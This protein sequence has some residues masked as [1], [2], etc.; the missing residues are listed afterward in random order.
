MSLR[1]TKIIIGLWTLIIALMLL[2]PPWKE[3][4]KTKELEVTRAIGCSAIYNPPTGTKLYGSVEID[5]SRLI[6][7]LVGITVL[8]G[9]IFFIQYK[10]LAP[11]SEGSPP[12]EKC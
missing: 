5:G 12:A 10:R 3:T 4:I 7:Q 8:F 6:M 1:R 9:G 11:H 2:L